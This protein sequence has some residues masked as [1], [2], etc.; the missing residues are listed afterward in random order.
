MTVKEMIAE[1][2]ALIANGEINED[3]I[4]TNAEMDEAYSI[5]NNNENEIVIYF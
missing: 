1:L 3:A 4:I 5:V 2:N